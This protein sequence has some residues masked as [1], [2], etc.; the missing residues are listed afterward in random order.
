MYQATNAL[1]IVD[2]RQQTHHAL[3]RGVELARKFG[4]KLTFA[5]C[6]YQN[7]I[8]LIPKNSAFDKKQVELEAKAHFEDKLREEVNLY[9]NED[10]NFY[11]EFEIIWHKHFKQGIVEH[12]NQNNFDLVI[13]TAHHHSR[14]QTLLFT[15][16][17]WALMRE[18]K[19]NLLFVK[20]GAWPS[21]TCIMGAINIESD[22]KHQLLNEA[23]VEATAN[24]AAA[25]DSEAKILNVFPWPVIDLEKFTYLF[26]KRDQFLD[27]KNHHK[28]KLENY[29]ANYPNLKGSVVIAEGLSPEET[30]PELIQSTKSDLLVMGCVGRKGLSGAMIGNTAEKI[31]DKID[32][33]VLVLQ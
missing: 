4:T 28:T 5:V 6:V 14:L 10:D 2:F 23:I 9:I 7:I 22:S 15:P 29:V 3:P 27:I 25:C 11:Y 31:L 26:S 18:T 16:S 30:I 1:V 12:I 13:K 32:C 24:L 19:A 33:E 20:K 8:D 17:D 21:S